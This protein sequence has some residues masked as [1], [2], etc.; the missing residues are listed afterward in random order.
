MNNDLMPRTYCI[1]IEHTHLYVRN[2][3][4]AKTNN[5]YIYIFLR[6][7]I[8]KISFFIILFIKYRYIKLNN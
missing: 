4:L 7:I 2:G 1:V 3:T 8:N 6:I 5:L